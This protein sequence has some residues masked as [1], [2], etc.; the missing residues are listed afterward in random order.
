MDMEEKQAKGGLVSLKNVVSVILI[1][2]GVIMGVLAVRSVRNERKDTAHHATAD[3]DK[4][5]QRYRSWSEIV[6]HDTLRIGTMTS[7]T[8]FFIYRGQE[9]GS[10]YRKVLAFAKK[11]GIEI[12]VHLATH[13]DSLR[14]WLDEGRI[15]LSITPF[16]MTKSNTERYRF[17]GMTDTIA[18]YLVQKVVEMQK[19]V[20]RDS[21]TALDGKEVFVA[22][23]TIEHVRMEQIKE[24]TGMSDLII[25]PV[26]TLGT[27]DLIGMIAEVDSMRYTV[28]DQRL[29][30]LFARHY[31]NLNVE[32]R[33]SVPIRY[34]WITHL[35]NQSLS[36]TIDEYFSS[37]EVKEHFRTLGEYD[38]NSTKFFVNESES[39]I[40]YRM[41]KGDIS[42]YDDLFKAEAGRL[43]WHWGYLAAIAYHESSFDSNVVGWSGARGLMGIMPATGRIY[44]ATPEELLDPAVSVRVSVDCLI[45]YGK[46]FRD[47]PSR[48]ERMCFTLAS[49][50]AGIGH[51]MDAIRLAEKYGAASDIWRG[52]VRE[53]LLLKSTPKYYNDP[54]VK[55]GYVRGSE[56]VKYVD[57][58]MERGAVY[59]AHM[60]KK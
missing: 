31:R 28:A 56:T 9:F 20:T 16:A 10:E 59:A 26:D 15:D 36:R 46:S 45:E 43:G 30:K 25:T 32:T 44:G 13:E 49:Y 3:M 22:S 19:P 39:P 48:H 38:S 18:L 60:S 29:A 55:N 47:N 12:D 50:N 24:E 14:L 51:V 27:E 35:D 41:K 23:N 5:L 17:C 57:N 21:I 58:I 34:G 4:G 53:Y 52:G 1:I 2:A 40:T 42:P 33:I 6:E 11:N 7:P 8:D 54:V 37:E